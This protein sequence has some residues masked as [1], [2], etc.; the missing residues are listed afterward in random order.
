MLRNELQCRHSLLSLSIDNE[1][2]KGEIV[3][4][5]LEVAIS[6]LE[7]EELILTFECAMSRSIFDRVAWP[8]KK[9]QEILEPPGK[10]GLLHIFEGFPSSD[11]VV[12]SLGL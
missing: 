12:F 11:V 7:S 8:E 9:T 3:I 2:R 4:D 1:D 6:E 5:E 10:V